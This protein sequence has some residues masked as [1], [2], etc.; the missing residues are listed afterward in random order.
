VGQNELSEILFNNA[1]EVSVV[2]S[3]ESILVNI[4]GDGFKTRWVKYLQ[5][6]SQIQQQYPA[7]VSVDLRFRNLVIVNMRSGEVEKKVIWDAE[8]KLL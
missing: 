3:S 1:A 8:K 5:L 4:G 7:A 6:K 2:S